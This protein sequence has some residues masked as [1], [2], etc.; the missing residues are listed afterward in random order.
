MIYHLRLHHHLHHNVIRE[1]DPSWRP[2]RW[3][4]PPATNDALSFS[5]LF[6]V[7]MVTASSCRHPRWP[8]L[9]AITDCITIFI[10]SLSEE[11]PV[12]AMGLGPSSGVG[13]D[14]KPLFSSTILMLGMHQLGAAIRE[15]SFPI[16]L[17]PHAATAPPAVAAAAC[18]HR[19]ALLPSLASLRLPVH[20]APPRWPPFLP[21]TDVL[22]FRLSHYCTAGLDRAPCPLPSLLSPARRPSPCWQGDGRP[23]TTQEKQPLV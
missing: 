23:S 14:R 16:L 17:L 21:T 9:P 15:R 18:H 12:R 6:V 20:A 1:A 4:P 2:P 8:P 3:P 10:E 11:A 5:L 22:K 13:I 7:M 19:R